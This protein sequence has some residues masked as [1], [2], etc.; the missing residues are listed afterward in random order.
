MGNICCGSVDNPNPGKNSKGKS[1]GSGK[2]SGYKNKKDKKDK[3]KSG[4]KSFV[5]CKNIG[6]IQ[7]KYSFNRRTDFLGKGAYGDVVKAKSKDNGH[8]HALK[9][10][11]K[12]LIDPSSVLKKLMMNELEIM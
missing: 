11:K 3:F 1:G 7:E 4:Y 2:G 12:S 9:M 5:T 10:I 6:G 8:V